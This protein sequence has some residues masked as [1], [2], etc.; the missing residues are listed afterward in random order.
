[1]Y[2][3]TNITGRDTVCIAGEGWYEHH[4]A[5]VS[6][7]RSCGRHKED[8]HLGRLTTPASEDVTPACR[9]CHKKLRRSVWSGQ[10]C[11]SS[12]SFHPQWLIPDPLSSPETPDC[13]LVLTGLPLNLI[14]LKSPKADR[15]SKKD[16]RSM[17]ERCGSETAGRKSKVLVRGLEERRPARSIQ[18]T[19]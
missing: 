4:H 11:V 8:T 2:Y 17:T 5:L 19:G 3:S 18:K 1:M 15:V 13:S 12:S 10:F 16:C 7:S 6:T 9:S 14:A